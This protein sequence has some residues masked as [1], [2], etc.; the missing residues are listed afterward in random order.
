[1]RVYI[2]YQNLLS[3]RKH[4]ITKDTV[5]YKSS[6]NSD[7]QLSMHMFLNEENVRTYQRAQAAG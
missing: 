4:K 5:I 1:M 2:V 6:K 7:F 3:L